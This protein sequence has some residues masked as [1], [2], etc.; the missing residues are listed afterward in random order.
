M[1]SNARHSR[2]VSL[3]QVFVR[4]SPHDYDAMLHWQLGGRRAWDRVVRVSKEWFR[5][6]Q[7]EAH[8]RSRPGSW[9]WLLAPARSNMAADGLDVMEV[10]VQ[11]FAPWVLFGNTFVQSRHGWQSWCLVR[12]LFHSCKGRESAGG[13]ITQVDS[14]PVWPGALLEEKLTLF[15]YRQAATRPDLFASAQGFLMLISVDGF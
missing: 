5:R 7:G 4:K 8:L 1:N 2:K 9:L 6:A 11:M 10:S 3:F 12:A 14:R 13:R 15:P